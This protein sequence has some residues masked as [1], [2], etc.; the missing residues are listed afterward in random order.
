MQFTPP[1][2]TKS[3]LTDSLAATRY[4]DEEQCVSELLTKWVPSRQ[5]QDTIQSIARDLVERIR[6]DKDQHGGLDAFLHE[7][8]LSSQEGVVLM[9]LAEAL[10]RV[11]DTAT[12]DKLIRD[13]IGDAD[14]ESHIGQSESLF[15]NAS[16]WALMLT[17][18]IVKPE[19]DDQKNISSFMKRLVARNGEPIIRTAVTRAMRIMGQQ[20]VLS[21]TV[22]GALKTA[23]KKQSLG[24]RHSY[25]MLGEAARTDTDAKRYF[26][27]YAAAIDAIGKAANG[28]SPITNP[29][30]S[31]KLSALH[32][33]YEFA[34]VER[35][36]NE[37]Y[38][39]LQSLAKKAKAFNINMT[40]DAEESDRLE[41][42]LA[43]FERLAKDPELVDWNG[44]GLAVQAYQKRAPIVIDWIIDLA[45]KTQR[46]FMVRLV[47][48][49]YW[50]TEIKRAQEMGLQDYPVFTRKAS[51]DLCYLVLRKKNVS[52]FTS[53][54]LPVRHAQCL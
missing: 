12:V 53:D 45:E 13:K 9:C 2:A 6:S 20:F 38:P 26:D 15:V 25:D 42:S 10:L 37:L 49:A 54:L 1:F 19:A 8:E 7:F 47:K 16:T 17:G 44:M 32:A 48:G 23:E 24:Y 35:V 40:I 29:G 14:W 41:L 39:R 46:R 31:V 33:R 11:P 27:E 30:I 18:K 50:D 28:D 22:G 36:N 52:A 51:T 21:E 4:C 34:K 43:I 3:S 5:Q